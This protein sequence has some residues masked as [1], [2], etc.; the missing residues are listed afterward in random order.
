M[1]C[2]L[3]DSALPSRLAEL[4]TKLGVSRN[5]MLEA[6]LSRLTDEQFAMHLRGWLSQRARLTG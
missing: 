4:S 5:K 3:E 6:A 1:V 2:E